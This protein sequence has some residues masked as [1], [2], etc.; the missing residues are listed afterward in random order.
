MSFLEIGDM[1]EA[2]EHKGKLSVVPY[3]VHE[4]FRAQ[5]ASF[6]PCHSC[7]PGNVLGPYEVYFSLEIICEPA[8]PI[9]VIDVQ[10]AAQVSSANIL[11][12]LKGHLLT[13]T[14]IRLS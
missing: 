5:R 9:K 4:A 7:H 6:C 14:F 2:N 8:V 13:T 12:Y 3:T 11:A 1:Q 10:C